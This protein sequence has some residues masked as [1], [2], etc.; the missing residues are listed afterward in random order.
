MIYTWHDTSTFS[1]AVAFLVHELL[2]TEDFWIGG[3]DNEEEKTFTWANGSPWDWTNWNT[4]Q[5]NH[6][7]GQNCL[8]VKKNINKWDDVNCSNAFKYACQKQA[9]LP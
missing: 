6:K 1:L 2:P 3:N 9:L 5:P 4:D 7:D 8:K